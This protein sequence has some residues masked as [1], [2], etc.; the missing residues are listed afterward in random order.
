MGSNETN[1]GQSCRDLFSSLSPL[2]SYHARISLHD[3]Q[4][5]EPIRL[6]VDERS[7]CVRKN[8]QDVK[9]INGSNCIFT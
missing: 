7:Y 9:T 4:D 5:P 8:D 3:F 1:L 2:S 6:D